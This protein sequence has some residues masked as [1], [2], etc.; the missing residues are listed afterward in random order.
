MKFNLN[1]LKAKTKGNKNAIY[2][3][4]VTAASFVVYIM[5][6]NMNETDVMLRANEETFEHLASGDRL[7]FIASTG[8]E[9]HY[10]PYVEV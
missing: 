9:Y 10:A 3:A 2:A 5:I 4:G 6:K 7:H 8:E 1:A